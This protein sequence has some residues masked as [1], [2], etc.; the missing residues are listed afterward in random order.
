VHAAQEVAPDEKS[1]KVPTSHA[2]GKNCD[3]EEMKY[4]GWLGVQA[5]KPEKIVQNN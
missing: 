5:V 3:G 2:V 1:E 4:P